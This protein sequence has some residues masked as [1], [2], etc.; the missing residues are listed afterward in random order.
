MTANRG[1]PRT[2]DPTAGSARQTEGRIKALGAIV[3]AAGL[4]KRM[5]SKLAKV[6]HPVAGRPMVL[7]GVELAERLASEGV[8]VVVGHQG[9]QVKGVIE[10][11]GPSAAGISRTFI[12][13][14]KEQLGTGHAVMQA[15]T[16]FSRERGGPA[17]RYVILN[18][19]TPL[20]KES[21]VRDLVRL[22]ETER[23]T[24]TMLTAVLDN[25]TG[26]G[27]VV[28][29]QAGG[30]S[31]R[32]GGMVLRIVEDRDSTDSESRIQEIN[33]GTYV[34][35]GPFLFEALERLKPQNAQK[36][37]YL[38]DIVALAVKRGLRVAAIATREAEEG[39][40][41][42]TREQLATAERV[43]RQQLCTHWMQAGVTLQDPATT[44]IDADVKIG[45]DT[46]L[47]PHVTLEGQ[48]SIGEGC[49]IRSHTRISDS[50]L[51]H[52]VA[53]HD[54][55]VIRDVRLEDDTSVGPFAHLRPGTV[56]RRS[57]KVGNFVEMKKTELGEGSKANH[58][59]YLGDARIGKGVN[60]GAGTITCNYDGSRKHETVIEDEVFV[61]SDTQLIA[62]V[63]VGRGAVIAAGSTVTENVPAD[64]L[65]IARALQVNNPGW[66]ARRRALPPAGP[67]PAGGRQDAR[68]DGSVRG[69]KG[70]KG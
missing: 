67:S 17:E 69:K 51:G 13:E 34:V 6:L 25:P 44:W 56:V 29:K 35:D 12:V 49:V 63:T 59:S 43:M 39:L 26:Y 10:A 27:R 47:H 4:G 36:E 18:G 61:G 15:R 70:E 38:T 30:R 32:Q 2:G 20:L 53:V 24:V 52:R 60:I 64:A 7:Y 62:P 66:A 5:R 3:M 65:A 48:T 50:R 45:Q 58:L 31:A 28:R 23:A 19:D 57:A 9:D 41:I 14:Q 46:V 21:T 37:Y 33:V 8:A 68:G 40:G 54:C 11:R 16:V 1:H 22:H 42:N 55:C